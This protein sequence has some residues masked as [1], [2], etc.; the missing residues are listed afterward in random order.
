[1]FTNYFKIAVRS[2]LKHKT[3]SLINVFGLAVGIA[4]CLLI[5]QFILDELSYDKF[6][7]NSDKV[8]RIEKNEITDLGEWVSTA[9][10]NYRL[11]P[12][13][14]A[15]YPQIK[16]IVRIHPANVL[17]T[18]DDN[19]KFQEDNFI[20]ADPTF[21]EVFS[22][23]LIKGNSAKVLEDPFS[24][25]LSETSAKK[26][27]GNAN[28]IGKVL[29]YENTQDFIVA[30]IVE[31]VPQN[32]H[33]KFDIVGSMVGFEKMEDHINSW[34]WPP[35]YTYLLLDDA[36][37]AQEISVGFNEFKK[38][39]LP[40]H[41]VEKRDYVL[42]NLKDIH[43]YSHKENEIEANSDILYIYVF[44]SIAVFILG[45]ACVNFIN[46][47][48]AKSHGRAKEVGMRK[49][50]GVH[51]AQLIRQFLAESLLITF[52]SVVVATGLVELFTPFF[53]SV[54]GKNLSVPFFSSFHIP[55]ILLGLIIIVGLISGSYPAFYLSS[56]QPV[57]VLKGLN[58][59]FSFSALFLRKGLVVFQFIVSSILII[60]T[61]IFYNQLSF[62]Q[63]KKLGFSKDHVVVLPLREHKDSQNYET[64]RNILMQNNDVINVSASSGV[65][66]KS[67]IYDFLI[68]PKN[69]S[70][71]SLS[72]Y[73]LSVDNSFVETFSMELLDG[74]DFSEEFSTDKNEAFV[75]NESA[76]KLLGWE[77]PVGQEMSLE[78]YT[79]TKEIKKGK[80][81]GL[82]KDFHYNSLHESIN[83]VVLHYASH[84]YYIDF[85]S[86]KIAGN[87]ISSTLSSIKENWREFS[88]N[89][90]FEY[91]FLDDEFN[92]LYKAETQTGRLFLYFSVLAICVA[93]LGLFGLSS[94]TAE[95]KTKEIG[96]RKTLGA[97]VS[98]VIFMLSK[99][100]LKLIGIAFMIATPISYFLLNNW[101]QNFA[102]KVDIGVTVY[103]FSALTILLITFA[104]VINQSLKAA[105]TDPV[106]TLKHE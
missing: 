23:K 81:V 26:Y 75:V 10:T 82:V 52:I 9:T 49:V 27:F 70:R 91:F 83:P 3:F 22:F 92:K 33:F 6:H 43:L 69:S 47:S 74:R 28:P 24:L 78:W 106:K 48:T 50:L 25:V 90:P 31:D 64:L 29:K 57:K 56:F 71:D 4:C 61:I 45:I 46:L 21:F 11:T 84:Y 1:M 102:Y 85:I 19:L 41:E 12:A 76:A 40:G 101:L 80:V 68:R 60:G 55:V 54:V 13:L 34:Y 44:G 73:V 97:S 99:S 88:P 42:T 59:N 79:N 105:L 18:A 86:V 87:N 30:G 7:E 5:Y 104:T 32:S 51:R 89:R 17:L 94:F 8:F 58:I 93:C 72:I 37:S 38:N 16:S 39:H 2:I 36:N 100:Y 77:N 98:D 15:E 103:L 67:G 20:F 14:K 53:N 96:I 65:P 66:G 63:N 95:Q 62:I 35:F